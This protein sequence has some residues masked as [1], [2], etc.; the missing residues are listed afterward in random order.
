MP[1]YTAHLYT[2]ANWAET[3]ISAA[4]PL[5]AL[6]RARVITDDDLSAL[7][8]RHYDDIGEVE[9][10]EIHTLEGDTVAEWESAD[11]RLRLAAPEMLEALEFVDMTF[12]DI[13]ASKR[14]GYYTE[15]PKIVAAA[16]ARAKGGAS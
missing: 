3:R 5:L 9:R 2:A 10:I 14:K 13:E 12:A 7:D 8:F 6:G 15:C 16:I 4:T 11:L 1:F